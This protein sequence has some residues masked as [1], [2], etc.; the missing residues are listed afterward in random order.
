MPSWELF[1]SQ[2]ADYQ[3][4]VLPADVLKISV[5]AGATFGWSRWVDASI[6]IDRF[7]A[8]GKGDKVLAHFGFSPEGIADQVQAKVAELQRA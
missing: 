4:S 1:E 8:S 6:G 3:E 2:D 7:G 5:E